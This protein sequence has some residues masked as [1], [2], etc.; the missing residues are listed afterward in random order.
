M[1]HLSRKNL[2]LDDLVK[3]TLQG[4][5]NITFIITLLK[6]KAL[7]QNT[8]AEIKLKICR[9]PRLRNGSPL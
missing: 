8:L 5:K 2:S 1:H 3:K 4:K 6:K 9:I 7:N